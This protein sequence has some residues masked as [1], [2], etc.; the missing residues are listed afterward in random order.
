MANIK[1][2]IKRLKT[3]E[4]SRSRNFAVKSRTKTFE[5]KA[6]N[7]LLNEKKDPEIV[8][9]NF[10][11]AMSEFAKAASKGVF[12]KNKAARKMSRLAN[13]FNKNNNLQIKN[14]LEKKS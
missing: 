13:F 14:N 8:K 10:D 5:K 2:K 7:I 1:S 6:K 12:H 9:K 3:N 11:K 4:K